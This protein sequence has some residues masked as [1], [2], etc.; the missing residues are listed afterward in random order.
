MQP[1]P[2]EVRGKIGEYDGEEQW[3]VKQR[4][5]VS[6]LRNGHTRRSARLQAECVQNLTHFPELFQHTLCDLAHTA[7]I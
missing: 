4:E 1:L 3:L 7:H 2:C 5:R 6:V